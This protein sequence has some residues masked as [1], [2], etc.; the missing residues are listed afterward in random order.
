MTVSTVEVLRQ[1]RELYARAP[2]H[3][4][5]DETPKRGTYC[6]VH[7][8]AAVA[9]DGEQMF[10]SEMALRFAARPHG[11]LVAWNAE[12]STETVLAA[13]DR[14]IEAEASRA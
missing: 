5:V 13:F 2:S 12:N 11:S 7:A 4:G 9:R 3:A 10:L 8:I 14:A 6:V 1:A